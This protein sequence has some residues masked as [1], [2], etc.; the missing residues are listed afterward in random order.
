MH[1]NRGIRC[2][3]LPGRAMEI[4]KYR[5]T[6]APLKGS[7]VGYCMLVYPLFMILVR[8]SLDSGASTPF[9]HL[10]LAENY[11]GTGYSYPP[12]KAVR[13]HSPSTMNHSSFQ[14]VAYFTFAPRT[15]NFMSLFALR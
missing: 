3:H 11:V 5:S 13:P 14:G 8:M 1:K 4:L 2:S 10:F 15:V 7:R 12:I 6:R 9:A